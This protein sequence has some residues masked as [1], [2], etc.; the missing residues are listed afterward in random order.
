MKKSPLQVSIFLLVFPLFVIFSC[1]KQGE[2]VDVEAD[3]TAIND[4][5]NQYA[6][7]IN[8]GDMNLWISL[9]A[10]DGIQMP[11]DNPAVIGKEKI[12]ARMQSSFNLY[13]WKMTIDGEEVRVAGDWA[14]TRGTYTYTLTPKEEGETIKGTGKYLTILEKQDDGS[15]KL[16]RD[17]F[18]N[19]APPK[20][21]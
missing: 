12:R 18:N 1:G 3:I 9:W 10:D 21:E 11:P 13:N 17:C 15:W 6:L 4:L 2:V 7:A 20:Q 5:L 14:F 8:A 16:A 19:N